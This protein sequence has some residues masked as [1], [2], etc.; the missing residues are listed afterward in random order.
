[1]IKYIIA[2]VVVMCFIYLGWGLGNYYKK[3]IRIFQELDD[4]LNYAIGNINFFKDST[5]SIY[6]SY[7]ERFNPSKQFSD[8]LNKQIQGKTLE[9][10]LYLKKVESVLLTNI[11]SNFGKSDSE[12]QIAEFKN[13]SEQIKIILNKC[14]EDDDKIGKISTKLG[15]LFGL[16]LAICLL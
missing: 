13:Y 14:R 1:M 9:N 12:N 11:F 10:T 15:F 3:R 7:L 8:I 16:A 5:C 2:I 4:F 6:N